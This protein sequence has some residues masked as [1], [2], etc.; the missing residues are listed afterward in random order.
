MRLRAEIT[1]LRHAFSN[2]DKLHEENASEAQALQAQLDQ[3]LAL[4]K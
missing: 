2:V 3:A 1:R 4:N